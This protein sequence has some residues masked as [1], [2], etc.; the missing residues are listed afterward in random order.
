MPIAMTPSNPRGST[1]SDTPIRD[2]GSFRLDVLVSAAATM[3]AADIAGA[4]RQQSRS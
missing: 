2:S 1:H 4:E 3:V